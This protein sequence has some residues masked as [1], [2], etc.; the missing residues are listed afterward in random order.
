MGTDDRDRELDR[1][2]QELA[3]AP[4][5]EEP[6]DKKVGDGS[7]CWLNGE[8]MCGGDCV[9]FNWESEPLQAPNQC[10]ALAYF[11]QV[12]SGALTQIKLSRKAR[13]RA[14]D[15]QREEAAKAEVPKP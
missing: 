8:R 6:G 11:G 1:L 15:R 4:Y 13:Q 10:I 5:I 3:G 2:E 14:E 7:M 12:A 9:A